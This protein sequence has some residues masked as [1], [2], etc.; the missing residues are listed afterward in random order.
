MPTLFLRLQIYPAVLLREYP[1]LYFLGVGPSK[2]IEIQI[3]RFQK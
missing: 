2:V 1:L 3:D